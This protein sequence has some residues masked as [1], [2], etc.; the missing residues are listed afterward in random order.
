[1][2]KARTSRNAQGN[3]KW[4]YSKQGQVEMLKARTSGNVQVCIVLFLYMPFP[5]Y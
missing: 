3:D 4:K 2:F 5:I 1:M